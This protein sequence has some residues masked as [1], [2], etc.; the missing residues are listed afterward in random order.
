MGREGVVHRNGGLS[1]TRKG[2]ETGLF[3]EIWID[4]ES[5]RQREVSEKEKG[6]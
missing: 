6:K 2:N 4:L 3:V 5:V 1:L